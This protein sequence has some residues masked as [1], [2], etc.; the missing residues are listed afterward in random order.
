MIKVIEVKIR[1][2]SKVPCITNLKEKLKILADYD[3]DEE[4][5]KIGW[6]CDL[7]EDPTLAGRDQRSAE[8]FQGTFAVE[9]V[10]TRVLSERIFTRAFEHIGKN[11]MRKKFQRS[12][13]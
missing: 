6:S 4:L 2:Y 9:G 3:N 5:D 8:E 12:L 11:A 1:T 7:I 13:W 10:L